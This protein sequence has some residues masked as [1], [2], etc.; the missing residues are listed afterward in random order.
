MAASAG[1]VEALTAVAEGLPEDFPAAVFVVLHLPAGAPSA[2]YRILSRAGP[3]PARTA[4]DG[5]ALRAGTIAVAPPDGH[6]MLEPDRA[7]VLRG[8]KVNGHRPAAD[9]LF[10]SAARAHDG[11]TVGVVL[12]GMLSDGALGLRAIKRRNGAAV[13]Q[14][15]ALHTGMPASAMA[16][17][18]V[19]AAVPLQ[20]IPGVLT[21][22]VGERASREGAEMSE[23]SELEAGFDLSQER[24]T[25]GEP[26][27]FRCPECGGALWELEHDGAVGYACH[28]GHTYSADSMLEEQGSSVERALWGALRVLEERAALVRRLGERMQLRGQSRSRERF[29]RQAAEAEEQ[30]RAIRQ[31]LEAPSSQETGYEIVEDAA[32]T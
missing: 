31:M 13:V 8:P 11:R 12:S 16:H 28:V 9:V 20:E 2:L 23:E 6:L 5:E 27:I 21:M 3:L 32:S 4:E 24:D 17:V 15:D 26:S 18:E 10:H 25:P 19:D 1:G 7:R 29:E 14:A 22:L 30:A